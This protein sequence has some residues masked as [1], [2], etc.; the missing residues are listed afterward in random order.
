[1]L[2]KNIRINEK[3]AAFTALRKVLGIG[4]STSFS[5]CYYL[6]IN[7]LLVFSELSDEE[8]ELVKTFCLKYLK[9]NKRFLSIESIKT[10]VKN[11]SYRGFRHLNALPCRGQRTKTNSITARKLLA[12]QKPALIRGNW[13]R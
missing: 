3:K 4:K 8:R 10:L 1:M 11:K 13:G 6:G 2:L 12:K 7:P 5:I 9:S